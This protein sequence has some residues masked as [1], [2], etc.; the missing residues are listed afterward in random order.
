MQPQITFE[1][2]L[3]V[4]IR[5][6][7]ILEVSEFPEA[8]KPAYKLKIDFG[9]EIGVKRT[10]AQL[11][12]RYTDAQSLVGRKVIAVVNFPPKQVA[13]VMSEVLVLG[14]SDPSGGII[15]LEPENQ[16]EAPLGSRVH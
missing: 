12:L 13:N 1:D 7:K 4:D 14:V 2:F 9:A 3:K 6:G 5:V 10:S 16:D 15:L 8:R 11:T